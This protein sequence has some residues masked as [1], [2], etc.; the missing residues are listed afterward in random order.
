MDK[1]MPVLEVPRGTSILI[2][3]GDLTRVKIEHT[4]ARVSLTWE[5]L[6]KEVWRQIKCISFLD[7]LS[8]D[9]RFL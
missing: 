7:D 3:L 9:A 6:E 5:A 8:P 1:P 2:R 4:G